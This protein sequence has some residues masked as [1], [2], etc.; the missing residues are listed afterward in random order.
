MGFNPNLP[1]GNTY[2]SDTLIRYRQ[3]G[4]DYSVDGREVVVVNGVETLKGNVTID[5]EPTP[6]PAPED[7]TVA[8]TEEGTV[9]RADLEA[10]HVAKV[11]SVF[12]E[13]GGPEAVTTGAGSKGRMIDWLIENA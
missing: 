9:T 11:R 7:V 13:M 6:E 2:G 10:L 4:K 8:E 1:H 12:N 3:D 5:I